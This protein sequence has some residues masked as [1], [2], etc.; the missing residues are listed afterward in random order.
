MRFHPI[1]H[2]GQKRDEKV[3]S[4]IYNEKVKAFYHYLFLT[5]SAYQQPQ[6]LAFN[7]PIFHFCSLV[8]SK[9][10]VWCTTLI[11]IKMGK[12]FRRPYLLAREA[13]AHIFSDSIDHV[14]D[15]QLELCGPN[16]VSWIRSKQRLIYN[17]LSNIS[18]SPCHSSPMS[19]YITHHPALGALSN[20][21]THNENQSHY[22][23]SSGHIA[24]A[25]PDSA[26]ALAGTRLLVPAYLL[27]PYPHPPHDATL[28][29]PRVRP[30][31]GNKNQYQYEPPSIAKDQLY[32]FPLLQSPKNGINRDIRL[33]Y[34]TFSDILA[35]TRPKGMKKN[36]ADERKA[37][38]EADPWVANYT[39]SSVVCKGCGYESRWTLRE[40]NYIWYTS[41]WKSHRDG[42]PNNRTGCQ[43]IDH[44]KKYAQTR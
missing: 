23:S 32:I 38:F 31:I 17:L 22:P 21:D 19:R 9:C 4:S 25:S 20:T 28:Y 34:A 39:E 5:E 35:S 26:L 40:K 44:W 11:L 12:L 15:G 27:P 16:H 18:S 33:A 7:C 41:T 29:V 30:E 2:P 6:W 43:S 3:S 8:A 13:M 1:F 10:C 24:M 42:V 37:A 36:L 14:R